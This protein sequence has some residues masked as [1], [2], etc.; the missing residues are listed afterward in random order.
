MEDIDRLLFV[1]LLEQEAWLT[2]DLPLLQS[3]REQLRL[4]AG[5]ENAP[6][7]YALEYAEFLLRQ[8]AQ[9]A[10]AIGDDAARQWA[11]LRDV[12]ATDAQARIADLERVAGETETAIDLFTLLSCRVRLMHATGRSD[13][14]KAAISEFVA[15]KMSSI[16]SESGQARTWLAVAGLYSA[17]G[18]HA[19]AEDWYRRVTEVAPESY[20]MLV[21]ELAR[22]GRTDSAVEACLAAMSASD[23][24]DARAAAI[25]AQ[26]MTSTS[27]AASQSPQV[28]EA[29]TSALKTHGDDIELLMAVAV[30]NVTRNNN[31]EAIRYFDR[32]VELAPNNALALNN[33]A[34]LLA[35]RSE[36]RTRALELVNR[37][38]DVSGRQ[39]QLLD[40]L[41]T[42]QL[43]SGEYGQA[44]A[45]LQEAV[46]SGGG[47]PR[48]HFHLAAA[49]FRAE[50][51]NEARES[52]VRARRSGLGRAILTDGDQSLLQ[53]LEEALG[54][55]RPSAGQESRS[56]LRKLN[57]YALNRPIQASLAV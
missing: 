55:M 8:L 11:T 31:E 3:A 39:P 18:A 48:Y 2:E 40:T 12:F 15:N 22:Q 16:E 25:L 57:S 45:S 35:E 44:I 23:V 38:I 53:E 17:V 14:A 42:I 36:H 27:V 19:E 28:E 20:V 32:V 46:A 50:K 47:D 37:A 6:I 43:R 56:D 10:D 52:L 24:G 41:G 30:L 34:T 49:F 1:K 4:M 7:G 5:R 33:L 9:S 29:I 51:L 13:E 54:P 21:S 26:L